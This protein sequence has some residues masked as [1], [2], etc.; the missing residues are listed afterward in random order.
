M[1]PNARKLAAA[2]FLA[3]AFLVMASI[4][5]PHVSVAGRAG[6]RVEPAPQPEIVSAAL[7]ENL[8]LLGELEGGSYTVRVY[9]SLDGP[10]YT[11]YG[12]QGA[13]LAELLTA[14]QV[15]DRF[16]QLNLPGAWADV[17]TGE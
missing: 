13:A 17:P 16:P 7:G 4:F 9:G 3:A 2:A 8:P 10:R 1:K 12:S 11:V 14:Q 5:A 6:I 15:A